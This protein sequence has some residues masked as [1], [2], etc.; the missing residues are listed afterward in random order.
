[1]PVATFE[2]V[3]EN[4][5]LSHMISA[6]AGAVGN[7]APATGSPSARMEQIIG[8]I[9]KNVQTRQ[10]YSFG[11]FLLGLPDA[12]S[13]LGWVLD[14]ASR[15]AAKVVGAV[16]PPVSLDAVYGVELRECDNVVLLKC[17]G[18]D[19]LVETAPMDAAKA[20]DA[21]A[22]LR[23]VAAPRIL[24]PEFFSDSVLGG[25]APAWSEFGIG[26]VETFMDS[27]LDEAEGA[28]VCTE[29]TQ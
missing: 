4:L 16:S 27:K 20:A 13:A 23:V 19:R 8:A 28:A 1:M 9:Y 3:A 24:I 17:T 25:T 22:A 6:V 14:R 26:K 12:V 10:N 21:V 15:R 5:F 2:A 11:K 7:G 29:T 18:H